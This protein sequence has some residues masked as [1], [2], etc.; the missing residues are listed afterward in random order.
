[1]IVLIAKVVGV[2]DVHLYVM[3]VSLLCVVT[4]LARVI[5]IKGDAYLSTVS[6]DFP[7]AAYVRG[8]SALPTRL[9]S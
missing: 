6:N 4:A 5:H 3:Y 1:M 2:V 9:F 7:V 8:Y